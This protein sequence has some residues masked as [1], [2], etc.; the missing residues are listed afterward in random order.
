MQQLGPYMG[1]G[2]Q[3][4]AAM[5]AFGALGWWLDTRFGTTPWLLAAGAILGATGGMIAVIRTAVAAGKK[6][7]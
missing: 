2:F 7:Q 1:M 6:D 4:A 5:T 3:L